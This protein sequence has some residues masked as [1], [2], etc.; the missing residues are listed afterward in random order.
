[1]QLP[2]IACTLASKP[3]QTASQNLL[4]TC[5]SLLPV[6]PATCTAER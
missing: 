3:L 4:C 2:N 6:C 1:M 5:L